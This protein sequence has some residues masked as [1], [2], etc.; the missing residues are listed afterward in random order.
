MRMVAMLSHKL[1]VDQ[2]ILTR[3]SF[4]CYITV[5]RDIISGLLSSSSTRILLNGMPGDSI[6]HKRGLHQGDQ[7]SPVLFILVMDI[8]N[9]MVFKAADERLLQPHSSR[10]IQ[11]RVSLY[12][13][14]VVMFVRPAAVD[15]DLTV[16]ILHLFGEASGLKTNIQK[17]SAAPICYSATDMEVI[18]GCLTCRV[19]EFPIKYLGLP[20]S[21]KKLKKSQLQPLIDRLAD[22]LPGWKS[23]LM[24]R[25]GRAI[26]VQFVLTAT[27][28]YAMA[29][30]LPPWADKVIKKI[31]R[32]YLWR[33]RK[34]ASGGH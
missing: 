29:L 19:E 25:A 7:L 27:L 1:H 20:L 26:H 14:D 31:R 18:Q 21:L 28:I 23:D 9:L 6:T 8:L 5:W 3:T 22:L 13:D 17:N 30:D 10:S 2:A 16:G 34:D 33:G 12:A 4:S 15:I 24:T 11:H 32:N